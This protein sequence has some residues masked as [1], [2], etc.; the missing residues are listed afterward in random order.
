MAINLVIYFSKKGQNYCNGEIVNLEKGNAEQ[1]AEYISEAVNADLFEVVTA[2]PY[3]DDYN[4][5]TEVAK[6]ELRENA[7]PK[8]KERL[9]SLDGYKNIFIVGPCWWGTYPM[10]MYTLLEKLDFR[11]KRIIPVMTHEG[12]GMGS[13]ERDIKKFCRSGKLVKGLAIQ[14]A[15]VRESEKAVKEWALRNAK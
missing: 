6:K 5:C 15:K 1:L 12:S 9:K 14:G 11:D 8:I 10:A 4:K 3:P 13:A 7:R 2:K